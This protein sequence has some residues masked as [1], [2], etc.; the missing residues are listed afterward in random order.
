M[1]HGSNRARRGGTDIEPRAGGAGASARRL[2]VEQRPRPSRRRGRRFGPRPAVARIG[3]ELARIPGG[4]TI[5]KMNILSPSS[6]KN[7]RWLIRFAVVFAVAICIVAGA[8][9]W[10]VRNKASHAGMVYLPGG[11]FTMGCVESDPGCK[12]D[13][14]PAHQVT[15]SPFWMDIHPVTVAEYLRCRKAGVCRKEEHS[16]ATFHDYSR[17]EDVKGSEENNPA[18][19]VSWDNAT[20]YC[21][22]KKKRLPTEA[23]YE[24]ALRGGLD[25]AVYPWGDQLPPPP[26]AGNFQDES[27]ARREPEHIDYGLSGNYPGYFEGYDDGFTGPSP[28]CAFGKNGYGLCDVAGNVREWCSDWFDEEYYSESSKK[29]PRGPADGQFR[30]A[31][32]SNFKDGP[33]G[34]RASLRF[35]RT[36][37]FRFDFVGFRCVRDAGATKTFFKVGDRVVAAK[38]VEKKRGGW[39]W[40]NPWPQGNALFSVWG[41]GPDDIFASG[42]YGTILHFDGRV[43]GPMHTDTRY[44]LRAISGSSPGDVYAVGGLDQKSVIL[45]FNGMEWRR[46]IGG[47]GREIYIPVRQNAVWVSNDG[48]DIFVAGPDGLNRGSALFKQ[49]VVGLPVNDANESRLSERMFVHING[50]WGA[51]STDLFAVGYAKAQPPGVIMRFDGEVWWIME[52]PPVKLNAIWG[53]SAADVFAV[54][55]GGAIL[56]F[57]GKKWSNQENGA[58]GRLNGVWGAS[59]GDVFA[60]G[61]RGMIFHFDG[62]WWSPMNSGVNEQLFGVWGISGKNVFAV[63]EHGVILHYD[64]AAWTEMS[65][66]ASA[67]PLRSISGVSGADIYVSA[68]EDGV[69]HF[70]GA[71]WRPVK[72]DVEGRWTTVWSA[73]PKAIYVGGRTANAAG[74]ILRY[75]GAAWQALA[76]GLG[77]AVNAIWGPRATNVFAAGT[78]SGVGDATI[79]RYDGSAWNPTRGGAA[80]DW[81]ALWGFGRKNIFAFGLNPGFGAVSH[82]DGRAWQWMN[83]KMHLSFEQRDGRKAI[84]S[85]EMTGAWGTSSNDL[86]AVGADLRFKPNGRSNSEPERYRRGIG[87]I[88]HFDGKE[89]SPALESIR[90]T[91]RGIWGWSRSEAYAVGD[92]GL[93]LHYDGANWFE[94][95]SGTARALYAVWGPSPDDVYIVGEG[96]TIL[97]YGPAH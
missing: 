73:S 56:H 81:R 91:P 15:L 44:E 67:Q 86:F 17:Y 37:D 47:D 61:E 87:I 8:A 58:S 76:T 88:L 92:E 68:D 7:E 75:D 82:F 1:N 33:F 27:Y 85:C 6:P 83:D 94:M 42:E 38:P 66:R 24:Y 59:H 21:S 57:D 31:R 48:H 30:I 19:F 4:R 43:W 60:V 90:A 26:G 79:L 55:D 3:A 72:P 95:E 18:T 12:P 39:D 34:T 29:D 70:D 97:H 93:I 62:Q 63:G 23:E 10:S 53:S 36:R 65:R 20:Q 78:S 14:K 71:S 64:G 9:L 74:V 77:F 2:A 54:G 69:L 11:E 50:L 89:W 28:V 35:A 41:T 96:G 5:C 40:V 80:R 46:L 52:R 13:E 49:R 25:G 84:D 16:Q 45:H 32:G 51:N 22:W